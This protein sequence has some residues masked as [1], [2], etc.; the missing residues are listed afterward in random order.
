MVKIKT[1]CRDS[2]DYQRKTNTEIVKVYR[3]T[4]P[5]LHTIQK[6]REYIRALN[7]VKLDKVFS[8]PFCFFRRN[9]YNIK[10]DGNRLKQRKF[11]RDQGRGGS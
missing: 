4:N 7:A 5:K 3:N 10:Q 11:R 2:N 1:I 8:K 6:A 9:M